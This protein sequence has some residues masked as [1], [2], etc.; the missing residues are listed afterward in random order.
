MCLIFYINPHN[1]YFQPRYAAVAAAA[2][3]D[4]FIISAIEQAH[5]KMPPIQNFQ[6][7]VGPWGII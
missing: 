6:M 4:S 7:G 3:D 1:K 5:L 2:D